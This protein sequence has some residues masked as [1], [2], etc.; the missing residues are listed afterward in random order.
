M[1]KKATLEPLIPQLP[2]GGDQGHGGL[3]RRGWRRANVADSNE[4][5]RL[6]ISTQFFR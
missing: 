6:L 1:I 5:D 4:D 2:E 3:P